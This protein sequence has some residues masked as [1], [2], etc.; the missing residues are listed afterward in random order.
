METK[1]DSLTLEC[2]DLKSLPEIPV[3]I[4]K[5]CLKYLNV[6]D[7]D[8]R[9]YTNL[10]SF[11]C[12]LSGLNR[13]IGLPES[14]KELTCSFCL[15]LEQINFEKSKLEI[16]ELNVCRSLKINSFPKTLK[17]I[18]CFDCQNLDFSLYDLPSSIEN[19]E[20]EDD[21]DHIKDVVIFNKELDCYVDRDTDLVLEN[22]DYR[23][24][25]AIGI[26]RNDKIRPLN[27]ADIDL[28][29]E[30]KIKYDFDIQILDPKCV[31]C[32]REIPSIL[33]EKCCHVP[34]CV[35]CYLKVDNMV[36]PICK[37]R[38]DEVRRIYYYDENE[39]E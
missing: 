36:C 33:L 26:I 10:E 7:L 39:R 21:C 11:E 29:N 38:N 31:C 9:P 6:D 20:I 37:I 5:L 24:K 22:S 14:L 12:R 35:R 17:S 32:R 25:I 23:D 16:L 28:C 27:K 13:I 30:R 1:D 3:S 8:L 2:E 19:I 18:Q 4:K 15:G 34:Y